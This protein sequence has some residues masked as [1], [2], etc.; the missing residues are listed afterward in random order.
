MHPLAKLRDIIL[1]DKVI[2]TGR[3]IKLDGDNSLVATRFGVK[4]VSLVDSFV[5]VGDTVTLTDNTITGKVN[6]SS[7]KTLR[8]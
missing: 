1:N 7:I 8:A 6:E 5:K 4:K 3:I 2:S